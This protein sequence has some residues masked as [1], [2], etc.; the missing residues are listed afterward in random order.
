MKSIRNYAFALLLLFLFNVNSALSGET[1]HLTQTN[2]QF[3][4]AENGLDHHYKSSSSD[5]CVRLNAKSADQRLAKAQVLRLKAGEYLFRV[6]NRDV[7][8]ALGFWLRGS[9][10]SRL[11]LPSVSGGG[12]GTGQSKDYAITLEQGKYLYSCPLNPTPDYILHVE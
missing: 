8:Y 2:C 11:T 9:G 4:E 5:D 3:V 12:I 6:K 7:P 10:F 1:I